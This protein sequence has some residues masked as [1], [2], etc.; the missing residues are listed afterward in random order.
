MKQI[1]SLYLLMLK[2]VLMLIYLWVFSWYLSSSLNNRVT[3][4]FQSETNLHKINRELFDKEILEDEERWKELYKCLIDIRNMFKSEDLIQTDTHQFLQILQRSKK[5][6]RCYTQNLN[7]LKV[8]AELNAD[9]KFKN[10]EMIQLH[11][12]LEFFWCSYCKHM[13]SWNSIYEMTLIAEEIISCSNCVSM[14]EEWWTREKRT[15]IYVKH[16]WS[17]IVLFY[18]IDDSLSKRKV[19]IIDNDANS[20]SEILLVIDTS[21]T[22]NDLRYELKSKLISATHHNNEKIIYINNRSSLK[23]FCKSVVDHI[24]EINCDIWM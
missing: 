17:N 6:Q 8:R 2:S 13:T 5:L 3:Q 18:N 7:E 23:V 9:M 10:C 19:N 12:N 20:R 15:N 11:D 14:L 21:L 4:N 16:L 1:E 24:F 22:I